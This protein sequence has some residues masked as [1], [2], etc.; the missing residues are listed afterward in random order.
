[1]KTSLQELEKPWTAFLQA[2]PKAG[3][4]LLVIYNFK[5]EML[6]FPSF[7]PVVSVGPAMVLHFSP[8]MFVI[9]FSAIVGALSTPPLADMVNRNIPSHWHP[10][11][12][13]T[14]TM[15]FC[16]ACMAMFMRLLLTAFPF[17]G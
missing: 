15:F 17:L 4:S 2:M 12:G 6:Y 7:I 11:I 14:F 10:F 13:F 1:M 3:S 16:S 8:S 9:V 5:V